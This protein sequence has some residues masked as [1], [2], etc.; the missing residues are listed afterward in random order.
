MYSLSPENKKTLTSI[1]KYLVAVVALGIVFASIDWDETIESF[2]KFNL[3]VLFPLTI[4]FFINI[5]F[6]ALRWQAVLKSM[7]IESI[8]LLKLFKTYLVG[9]YY[10]SVLP[11]SIGGDVIK[12]LKLKDDVPKKELGAAIFFERFWGLLVMLISTVIIYFAWGRQFSDDNILLVVEILLTVLFI[13]F[14][15][16][17][18]LK[19]YAIKI[20][21]ALKNLIG[22][23][24]FHKFIGLLSFLIE[25]IKFDIKVITYS[26]LFTFTSFVGQYLLFLGLN[27]EI[28]F[29]TI[30]LVNPV[31]KIISMVPVSINSLGIQEGAYVYFYS[32][33]G[34]ASAETIIVSILTRVLIM[35]YNL[36]GFFFL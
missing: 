26:I 14:V 30:V 34:V 15:V 3:W 27:S 7:E 4:L 10:N 31:I 13:G 17:L 19:S 9:G 36:T 29:L 18:M 25:N 5:L 11:S 23:K 21:T 24:L 22:F 28:N 16:S 35:I 20:M 2:S 6:S 8:S 33:L 1:I 12:Y 32:L